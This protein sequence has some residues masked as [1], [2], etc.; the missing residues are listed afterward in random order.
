MKLP[1]NDLMDDVKT[2]YGIRCLPLD[3]NNLS[4]KWVNMSTKSKQVLKAP[5]ISILVSD[6]NEA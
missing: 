6:D 1:K 3:F 4:E 2:I 5:S